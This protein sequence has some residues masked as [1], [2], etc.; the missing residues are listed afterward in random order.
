MYI[1]I[2]IYIFCGAIVVLISCIYCYIKLWYKG[3]LKEKKFKNNRKF[4]D[5]IH[6]ERYSQYTLQS[7]GTNNMQENKNVN[8]IFFLLLR[9]TIRFEDYY[10]Y[11]C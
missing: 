1:I 4:F 5:N 9:K 3:T 7:S 11:Q 2:I 6:T 10:F 8:S